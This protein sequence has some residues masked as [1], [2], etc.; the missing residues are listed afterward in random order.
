MRLEF[1]FIFD[2]LALR[3]FSLL[4]SKPKWRFVNSYIVALDLKLKGKKI[5]RIQG[6]IFQKSP[7]YFFYF[8]FF[9]KE[10][11]NIDCRK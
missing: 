11:V 9:W 7:I 4:I 5:T 8:L 2:P 3:D 1:Y 10:M 6:E